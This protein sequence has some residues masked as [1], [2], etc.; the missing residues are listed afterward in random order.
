MQTKDGEGSKSRQ[1]KSK[2]HYFLKQ[3][4]AEAVKNE[5]IEYIEDR[6][7]QWK[8]YKRLTPTDY[9]VVKVFIDRSTNTYR[10]DSQ[11]GDDQKTKDDDLKPLKKKLS[12]QNKKRVI[13][14]KTPRS[15]F[16]K[17]KITKPKKSEAARPMTFGIIDSAYDYYA[18]VLSNVFTSTKFNSTL[19]IQK[20]FTDIVTVPQIWEYIRGVFIKIIYENDYNETR[21]LQFV[22]NQPFILLYNNILVGVPRIRQ[23][24][25]ENNSCTI[26]KTF[27][28]IFASCYGYLNSQNEDRKTFGNGTANWNYHVS[29]DSLMYEGLVSNYGPGGFSI[30]FD[31]DQYITTQIIEELEYHKWI[32]LG[33]RAVFID[34]TAYTPNTNLFCVVKLV[35]EMPPTGGVLTSSHFYTMKF[36]RYVTT[37]D[38]FILGCEL[39][40][41]C[42]V[43]YYITEEIE[44]MKIFKSAYF[45]SFWNCLDLLI[46]IVSIIAIIKG[47][48]RYE[49][50]KEKMGEK[51]DT[52]NQFTHASFDDLVKIQM[53]F[54]TL[55]AIIC[56]LAW[57]KFLKYLSLIHSVDLVLTIFT[58]VWREIA[59][60]LLCLV[61]LLIGFGMFGYL[62]FGTEVKQ[63]DTIKHSIISLVGISIG[64]IY[65]YK[66]CEDVRPNLAPL[67]FIFYILIVYLLFL[68]CFIALIVH[69]FYLAHE[70]FEEQR[71]RVYLIDIY[72]HLRFNLYSFFKYYREA[73]KIQNSMIETRNKKI[74]YAFVDILRR[75]GIHGLELALI[76]TK[77]N[78]TPGGPISFET[79][80]K[81]YKDLQTKKQLYLEVEEHDK[82][83]QQ[84][85][86][87]NQKI[88]FLDHTLI[89]M[90]TKVDIL[91]DKLLYQEMKNK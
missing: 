26:D 69:G 3:K 70:D 42:F 38:Y 24:R 21:S 63:F 89:D 62:L 5:E 49:E 54:N 39:I 75:N 46:I 16:Q 68:N 8:K 79:M 43:V 78:L 28:E 17:K 11:Q 53:F 47:I 9:K 15:L 37:W 52:I 91:V 64:G 74:Y 10:T 73:E 48:I 31:K 34:F 30:L 88:E 65:F 56:F 7:E 84:T 4:K 77:F 67:Y 36:I 50:V 86:R 18:S 81:I 85:E 66:D 13:A 14:K 83:K 20:T 35:L 59:A 25:V 55:V 60:L 6:Y 87:I 58:K 19:G 90:M 61:V 45:N 44:K 72:N 1:N 51:V 27:S 22:R 29:K 33:T 82:I 40:F 32:Q 41:I 76:L 71:E 12:S 23:V 57:L 2:M 80:D